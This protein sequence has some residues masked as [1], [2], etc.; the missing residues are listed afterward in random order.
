MWPPATVSS[1]PRRNSAPA[2]AEVD[3]DAPA[4]RRSGAGICS[5]VEPCWPGRRRRPPANQRCVPSMRLAVARTRRHSRPSGAL[6]TGLQYGSARPPRAATSARAQRTRPLTASDA[7][8]HR[9]AR[10]LHPPLLAIAPPQTRRAPRAMAIGADTDHPPAPRPWRSAATRP[11]R[12]GSLRMDAYVDAHAAAR[13]RSRATNLKERSRP[14]SRVLSRTVIPLGR[15]SPCAS[16]GLPGSDAGRVM[17]SLFGLAP[18]GVCRAGPL[19][20][21]RCALTAPFHPCLIRTNPPLRS[22]TTWSC[23]R[24]H[25]S[26][27]FAAAARSSGHRRYLSVALSVGSRRPGVTW[28]RALR[29][30][31]FPPAPARQRL[32]GRLQRA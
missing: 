26:C 15:M 23:A 16:C 8:R 32:S 19:P 13:D 24:A 10:D 28:H 14:V 1:G 4:G 20:D 18:G 6:R 7:N 30:P 11:R 25:A 29:S 17:G 22:W 21:S 3:I 2:T 9:H 12:R 27:G 5:P 31:D